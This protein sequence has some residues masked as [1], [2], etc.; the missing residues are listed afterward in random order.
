MKVYRGFKDVP[1][2]AAL[3]RQQRRE[4]VQACWRPFIYREWSFWVGI[5]LIHFL[6]FVGVVIGLILQ[7]QIGVSDWGLYACSV[8]G[9]LIGG[10]ACSLIFYTILIERFRPHLREYLATHQIS[11]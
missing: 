9:A 3:S 11:D 10:L 8:T 1:E 7:D 2:L 6:G 5:F 4:V